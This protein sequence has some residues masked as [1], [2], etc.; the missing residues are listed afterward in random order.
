MKVDR[1]S[2]IASLITLVNLKNKSLSMILNTPF[3]MRLIGLNSM[4][5]LALLILENKVI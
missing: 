2:L 3:M 5:I 1:E 4:N